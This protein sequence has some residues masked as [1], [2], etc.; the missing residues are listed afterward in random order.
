MRW[1]LFV[2]ENGLQSVGSVVVVHGLSCLSSS[3]AWAELSHGMW[4]LPGPGMELV[5]SVLV[6]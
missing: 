4:D 3:G 1:L 6:G 5:F 2:V